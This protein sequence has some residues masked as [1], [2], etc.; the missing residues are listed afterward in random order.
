M[1]YRKLFVFVISFFAYINLFSQSSE[2]GKVMYVNSIEGLRIRTEPAINSSI[3]GT[4]LYGESI[5]IEEKTS[6]TIT[7][8]GITDYW[9]KLHFGKGWVFGGYL[10]ENLPSNAL[11]IL[12][13]W[14]VE[15]NRIHMYYFSPTYDYKIG[16]KESEWFEIGKWELKENILTF[17]EQ[18]YVEDGSVNQK[19][20]RVIVSIMNNNYIRLKYTNGREINLVRCKNVYD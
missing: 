9:Y 15:P 20:T 17:V 4:F 16:R 7:I 13:Y 1:S 10:S 8:D 12:G 5:V 3:L 19:I 14:E 2:I 6:M 11:T 18:E